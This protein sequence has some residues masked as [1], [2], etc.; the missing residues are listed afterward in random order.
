MD[1]TYRGIGYSTAAPSFEATAMTEMTEKGTFRG[2][3]FAWKQYYSA[4][5][6]AANCQV[7]L[8]TER[9]ASWPLF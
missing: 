7:P 4:A 3:R 2:T 5:P 6:V 9:T 1:L 8:R